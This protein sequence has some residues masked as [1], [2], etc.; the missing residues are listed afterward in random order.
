ML[1]ENI[2]SDKFDDMLKI[3][4]EMHRIMVFQSDAVR[5]KEV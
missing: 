3:I 2:A 5:K 1:Y 4:R